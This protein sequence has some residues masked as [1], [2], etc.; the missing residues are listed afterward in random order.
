MFEMDGGSKGLGILSG[1]VEGIVRDI[2]GKDFGLRHLE[3]Q[4]DGN[5]TTPSADIE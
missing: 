2:P 1:D 3:G 5:T 4:G